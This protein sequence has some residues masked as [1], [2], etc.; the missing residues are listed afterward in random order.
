MTQNNV[1]KQILI[2]TIGSLLNLLLFCLTKYTAFPFWLDYT[3]TLYITALCGIVMGSV[4]FLIHTVLLWVLIDGA[5]SLLPAIPIILVMAT[6]YLFIK[7]DSK[8]VIKNFAMA[9]CSIT[10]AFISNVLIF[11][12]CKTPIGRYEVY[13]DI[14]KSLT[15]DFGKFYA[16]FCTS[17]AIT[18]SELLLCFMILAVASVLTPRRSDNLTF[19]K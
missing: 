8:S 2:F 1:K 14:F 7:D 17:A 4:S 11:L 9:L 18:F 6:I 12:C 3:G 15:S 13:S 5:V 10:I 16:A 19:K